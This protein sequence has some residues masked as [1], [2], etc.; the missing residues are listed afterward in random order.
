MSCRV[1]QQLRLT[2]QNDF[3]NSATDI[4]PNDIET[5][6]VL[7]GTAAASIYGSAAKNGAIL[8]T[9][10]KG[11]AGKLHV[12]YAGSVNFSKVGKLPDMQDQ[13]GQGWNATFVPVKTAA[14][15]QDL[16]A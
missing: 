9:T 15:D 4:N 11:K 13:F 5:I 2:T 16:M 12:D 6:T 3:G 10:K 14:G 1:N 7:K 8:I